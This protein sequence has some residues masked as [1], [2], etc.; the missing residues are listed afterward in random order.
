M[1]SLNCVGASG[2]ARF[3]LKARGLRNGA[4][5]TMDAQA[6][7]E[8]LDIVAQDIEPVELSESIAADKSGPRQQFKILLA[9][10]RSHWRLIGL[11]AFFY[12][13]QSAPQWAIPIITA[14][15][16][17]YAT[18]PHKYNRWYLW[19]NLGI[20]GLS[21]MQNVLS[22]SASVRYLSRAS[23]NV[24]AELRGTIVRKL[25]KLSM[26]YQGD[27]ANGK[28]Q[29]KVLRDVEGV[30]MLSTQMM[31][32]VF[33]AIYNI[34]VTLVI[35]LV[36]SPLIML[37]FLGT[38]PAS[39]LLVWF[40][41]GKMQK[42]NHSFRKKVEQM[43]GK[44]S[45]MV[46][47][48]PVT[49]SHG[50]EEVEVK[51]IDS[52]L[53][54]IKG[55]GHRL[56]VIEAFFGAFTWAT[57]QGFQLCCLAF[58]VFWV[59][60]GKMPVG[61]VV[62][63]QSFFGM[64]TNGVNQIITVYPTIVKGLESVDSVGEVLLADDVEA[65]QGR[66]VVDEL[67]GDIRFE[68]LCFRYENAERDVLCDLDFEVKAG[69]SIAL[70]GSSGSG[71]STVLNLVIG[72]YKPHEGRVLVDG[73]PMEELDMST[74]R[75]HLAVVL[76]NNIL[77]SGSIRDNIT[78]GLHNISDEKVHEAI[79]MANLQE[80]IGELP[81]G[82]DTLVGEHGSKLSGGQRQRIA[83]ARALIRDPKIIILDEATSAL[84]TV[85][86]QHVQV[87]LGHLMKG[88]TTFIVA[89]RL[90]TIRDAGRILVMEKGAIV[91]TGNYQQ[92]MERQG[93]FF[94]LEQAQ[95]HAL[96]SE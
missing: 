31:R 2:K 1:K 16:I 57:F 30:E 84:D 47:M 18:S 37:F 48:L 52:T 81:D 65:Y 85:S 69:E 4:V 59:L 94:Q 10:Y 17:N 96:D 33:P 51:K 43:S 67:I 73:M 35:V 25:Q 56:D 86:E 79:H 88:R 82:I 93:V 3:L 9:L 83:I 13:L 15:I 91:E 70:V 24:E 27:L 6:I 68:S 23:R 21:L 80:V 75:R 20:G 92:L 22:T 60:R 36:Q 78:Y 71:K 8:K 64:I 76:Q 45:E 41:Q 72:F 14:N 26:S 29:S 77:F 50:L 90:S 49:R 53:Q 38:V 12:V 63:Y 66:R 32:A 40:F 61:N 11:S 87:A 46:D 44:V 58:S 62:M 74:Y 42:R 89:H 55:Q 39:T 7:R 34:A 95:S 28:L 54:R 5:L 19:S